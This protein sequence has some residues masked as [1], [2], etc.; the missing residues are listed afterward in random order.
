MIVDDELMICTFVNKYLTSIGY[1]VTAFTDPGKAVE[2]YRSSFRTIDCI[3]MD[4]NMPDMDGEACL[5]AILAINPKARALISTGF[6]G[7]S[8]KRVKLPGIKGYISKPFSFGTL[9]TAINQTMKTE[10]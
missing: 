7:D 1:S 5:E 8:G 4:M 6:M 9:V 2:W 10:A 3:I